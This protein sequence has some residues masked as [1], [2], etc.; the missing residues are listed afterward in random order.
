MK[1]GYNFYIFGNPG[2][3]FSAFP[4]DYTEDIVRP[5][6]EYINSWRAIIYRKERLTYYFL[7]E[8]LGQGQYFG[9]G[10]VLNETISDTPKRLFDFIV[11]F[12][13]NEAIEKGR[14]IAFDDHANMCYT[15]DAFS[16]KEY[17]TLRR[18]FTNTLENSSLVFK[19]TEGNFAPPNR[20][21][22]T[23]DSSHT[24]AE[25]IQFFEDYNLLI[26]NGNGCEGSTHSALAELQKQVRVKNAEIEQLYSDLDELEKSKKQYKKINVLAAILIFCF[27]V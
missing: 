10:M 6:C 18:A 4:F 19:R 8:N 11:R 22:L 12:I 15:V 17:R 14:I 3:D 9:I 20:T 16:E 7:A 24:D 23:I 26:V 21:A 5:N 2:G 27:G 1:L 25:V 13:E